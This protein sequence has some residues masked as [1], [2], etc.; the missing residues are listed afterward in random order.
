[1][2]N[3]AISEEADDQM[4][5]IGNEEN[6]DS[7]CKEASYY[8]EQNT[9]QKD[10]YKTTNSKPRYQVSQEDFDEVNLNNDTD[11]EE[12]STEINN[13]QRQYEVPKSNMYYGQPIKVS[14]QTTDQED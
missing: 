10:A 8:N 14:H 12:F 13:Q 6:D 2:I 3:V 9:N 7:H 1:M 5:D 4:E 11:E